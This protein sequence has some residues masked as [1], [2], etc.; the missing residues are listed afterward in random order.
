MTRHSLL[1]HFV[2]GTLVGLAGGLALGLM[3]IFLT[4]SP[5]LAQSSGCHSHERLTKL[6]KERFAEHPVAAGLEASGRL[7]E[8]FASTDSASW[9][10][11]TTTPAGESCVIAVGE[12]WLDA[13]PIAP[14]GPQV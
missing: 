9:T 13:K 3:L 1:F 8:L 11:V 2:R 5:A 7:I 12:H 14:D 10:L 4:D 6:L